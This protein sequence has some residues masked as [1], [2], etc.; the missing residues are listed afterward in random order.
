MPRLCLFLVVPAMLAFAGVALPQDMAEK[1]VFSTLR[2]GQK[3]ILKE[4]P[5]GRYEILVFKDAPGTSKITEIG[6]DY[7]VVEDA[8]GISELRIPVTSISVIRTI[9]SPR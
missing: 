9:K 8:A 4:S 7:L 6:R 3:I 5:S 2:T 1:S